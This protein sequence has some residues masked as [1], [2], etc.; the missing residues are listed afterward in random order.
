MAFR[1]IYTP[2]TGVRATRGYCLKWVDDTSNAP[3]RTATARTALNNEINARRLRT[4]QPPVGIWVVG[5]LDMTTGAYAA[6]DHVFL[7]KYLGGGNYEI[8]DSE[9]NS[10]ARGIYHNLVELT[11][12]FGA[13]HPVYVGWSTQC[14]G[15]VYAEEYTPAP[16]VPVTTVSR[17]PAKGVAHVLVPT[18]HV[19]VS[20]NTNSTIVASYS[21]GQ[22]IPYDSYVVANGYVWL[23][24]IGASGVRRYVAEGP[25]DGR[26]DTV[27][28]SGGV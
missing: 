8:R 13:Y 12:W 27:Y 4:S 10:G 3:H 5:F 6:A 21:K 17:V 25:N 22:A 23:S 7:M 16:T 2:N 19:R 18:L 24:Y 28:V 9:T 11:S 1:Q 26:E 20:A 15:R 14:D